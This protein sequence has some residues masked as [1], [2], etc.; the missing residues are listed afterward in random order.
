MLREGGVII[1]IPIGKLSRIE[2]ARKIHLS[3]ILLFPGNLRDSTM[4]V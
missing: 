1:H 4:D 3:S 2:L